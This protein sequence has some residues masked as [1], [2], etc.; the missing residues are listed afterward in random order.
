MFQTMINNLPPLGDRG[1]LWLKF[2]TSYSDRYK[3]AC[4]SSDYGVTGANQNIEG[5]MSKTPEYLAI[6]QSVDNNMFRGAKYFSH[7]HFSRIRVESF[8]I[9]D[10]YFRQCEQP[11][12]Q[13]RHVDRIQDACL[14]DIDVIQNCTWGTTKGF[15]TAFSITTGP[16]T[17]RFSRHINRSDCEPNS[18]IA[19]SQCLN[20]TSRT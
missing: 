1:S 15:P 19:G 16:K 9:G 5:N 12:V 8:T 17:S 13:I 18:L 6:F 14:L 3:T 20:V 7:V 11:A 2:K 4:C 10:R